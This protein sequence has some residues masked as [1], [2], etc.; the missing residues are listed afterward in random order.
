MAL[1]PCPSKFYQSSLSPGG[2]KEIQPVTPRN[3]ADAFSQTTILHP[4]R[5]GLIAIQ[6]FYDNFINHLKTRFPTSKL[7]LDTPFVTD[8]FNEQCV[9]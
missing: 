3:G 9:A 2:K 4:Q 5:D 7:L 8:L 1:R 6:P